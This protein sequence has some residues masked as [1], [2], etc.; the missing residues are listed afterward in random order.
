MAAGTAALYRAL[1][2]Y[3]RHARRSRPADNDEVIIGGA[4]SGWCRGVTV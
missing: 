1:L 4:V 2:S 3:S